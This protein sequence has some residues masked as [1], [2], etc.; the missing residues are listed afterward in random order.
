MNPELLEELK[1]LIEEEYLDT[2]LNT[3]NKAFDGLKPIEVDN[4]RLRRM[5]FFIKSGQPS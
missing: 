5:I 3:P 2:W 1:D 4:S